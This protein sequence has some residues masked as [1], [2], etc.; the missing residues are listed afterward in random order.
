MPQT[1]AGTPGTTQLLVYQLGSLPVP[2]LVMMA[3]LMDFQRRQTQA[4]S[5]FVMF[6]RDH[7]Q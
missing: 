5:R 7:T 6:D 2:L 1:C 3:M 4:P